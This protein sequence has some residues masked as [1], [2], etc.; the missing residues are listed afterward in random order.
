MAIRMKEDM[1]I[2]HKTYVVIFSRH[3]LYYI[4]NWITIYQK[5]VRINKE[6]RIIHEKYLVMLL[7]THASLYLKPD[8]DI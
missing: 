3:M 8:N 4:L 7:Q 1:R 6:M 5:A 2:L